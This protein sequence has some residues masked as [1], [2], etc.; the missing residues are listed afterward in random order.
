M[1]VHRSRQRHGLVSLLQGNLLTLIAEHQSFRRQLV[2]AHV[3]RCHP[4]QEGMGYGYPLVLQKTHIVHQGMT[5][6]VCGHPCCQFRQLRGHL[7]PFLRLQAL[8]QRSLHRIPCCCYCLVHRPIVNRLQSYDLARTKQRKIFLFLSS[9]SI[10]A[11]FNG[12]NPLLF[13]ESFVTQFP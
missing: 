4:L 6:D 7:H 13:H 10:F 3:R 9:V 11:V 5:D 12:I 2:V 1:L 8:L